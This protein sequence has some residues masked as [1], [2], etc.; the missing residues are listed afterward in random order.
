MYPKILGKWRL[1]FGFCPE[2]NSD[3]PKLYDC[4]VC[5]YNKYKNR[6]ILWKRFTDYH[7]WK[8]DTMSYYE[9]TIRTLIAIIIISALILAV[10]AIMI[11]ASTFK[12]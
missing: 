8:D 5:Q 6:D 2:C 1:L 12:S 7:K 9:T 4:P 3:A 10:T 11:F